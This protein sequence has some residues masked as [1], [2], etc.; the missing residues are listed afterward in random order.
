MCTTFLTFYF[1]LYFPVRYNRSQSADPAL[2]MRKNL[3]L[4]PNKVD[5]SLDVSSIGRIASQ[6]EHGQQMTIKEEERFCKEI[7]SI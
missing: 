6:R 7:D 1:Y 2:H 4:R 3:K 5:S